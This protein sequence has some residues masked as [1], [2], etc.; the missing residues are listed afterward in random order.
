MPNPD[1]Q[2]CVHQIITL[3]EL[4]RCN[5]EDDQRILIAY[6]GVVFDV[7]QSPRWRSG[8]HEHLH[9]PGQDLTAELPEAPHGIEV[10]DHPSIRRIGR[11]GATRS[12]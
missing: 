8:L 7:S 4:T 1:H 3:E 9:F 12:A 6:N 10:F 11:L 5:G 2:K